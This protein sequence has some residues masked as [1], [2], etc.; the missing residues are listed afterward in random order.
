MVLSRSREATEVVE[1]QITT[2]PPPPPPPPPLP[3]L[4]PPLPP[5]FPCF[6][7]VGPH[8]FDRSKFETELG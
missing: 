1:C 6:F 5:P 7:H 3:P 8:V 4:P 2:P